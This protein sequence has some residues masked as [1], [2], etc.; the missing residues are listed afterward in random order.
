MI[1]YID[2]EFDVDGLVGKI[3]FHSTKG[4]SA[5]FRGPSVTNPTNIGCRLGEVSEV[6]G[7]NRIY[8]NDEKGAKKYISDGAIGCFCDTD[9]EASDLETL[10]DKYNEKARTLIDSLAAELNYEIGKMRGES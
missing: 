6:N 7:P 1:Q 10:V 5:I 9:E 8:Y 3:I 2:K 4:G